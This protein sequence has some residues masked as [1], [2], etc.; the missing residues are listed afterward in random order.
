MGMVRTQNMIPRFSGGMV[1]QNPGGHPLRPGTMQVRMPGSINTGL[2]PGSVA[3][4]SH[5]GQFVSSAVAINS[6]APMQLAP[7]RIRQMTAGPGMQPTGTA[8][9]LPPQYPTNQSQLESSGMPSIQVTNTNQVMPNISGAG[10]STNQ[11]NIPQGAGPS[12]PGDLATGPGVP[13]N[14]IAGSNAANVAS[15]SQGTQPANRAPNSADPEKRKLIQQQLVLLLHAH[16]CQ[17]REKGLTQSGGQVSEC[18][19]PHCKT[20]KTVLIHM[21]SCQSGRTCTVPHC[22]C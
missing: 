14:I 17:R 9:N 10:P 2:P 3:M 19:L 7:N 16:K 4:V 13:N 15:G 1:T 5:S 20:M 12:T 11:L 22:P 18:N 8:V 6:S 21:T